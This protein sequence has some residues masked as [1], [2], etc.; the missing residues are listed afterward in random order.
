MS[1]RE[2]GGLNHGVE[3]DPGK[4]SGLMNDQAPATRRV[5]YFL[6]SGKRA[7]HPSQKSSQGDAT[8][9][10]REGTCTLDGKVR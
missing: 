3:M 1:E 10:I 2:C 5:F 7:T 4:G 8:C 9:V 6:S